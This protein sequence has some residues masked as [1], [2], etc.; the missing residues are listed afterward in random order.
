M[1]PAV[2]LG[3]LCDYALTG[4]DQRL[5][6][7]GIFNNINF[8]GLPAA[9]PQF[10]VVFVLNLDRGEHQVHLG[11]VNP[12]GQQMLPDA[13]PVDVEVEV[14]GAETNLVIGFNNIQFDR[15]GIYQV[16]LF[17]AGRLVHSIPLNVQAVGPGPYL[18]DRPN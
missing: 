17:I 2:R 3:V 11:I 5:S 8:P 15:P 16:Q 6:L 18:S 1:Q 7:I 9:Y 12:T 14:P 10:F 13:E 4:M